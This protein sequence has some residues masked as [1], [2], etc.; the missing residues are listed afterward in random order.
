[1]ER[2]GDNGGREEGWRGER[3]RGRERKGKKTP[4]LFPQLGFLINLSLS[5]IS[6]LSP[7]E[8]AK[9]QAS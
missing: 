7:G 5:R 9:P 1:M 3:M 4:E 2:E 8:R 6:H